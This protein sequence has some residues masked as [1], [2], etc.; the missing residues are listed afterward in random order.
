MS[1]SKYF[2]VLDCYSGFWQ[3]NIH[4]PHREKTAF[5]VPSLGHFQFNRLPFGLSNSPASFQRLM[6]SIF[7]NLTGTECWIFL[8]DLILFSDKA[9]E[10][11]SRLANV[12]ERFR[13]ANLQLQPEKCVFVKDKV[14]YL[15]SEL[16]HKGTEASP[17]KV[18]AVQN[19]PT[20]RSVKN[21]R[22]FLGLA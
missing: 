2:S 6:D 17:D 15:G 5:S 11:A 12:F 1:G 14:T 8:D 9:E 3:I 19:F 21:V 20:P 7:R 4:E 16:S 22:S 18:K 10:H 13:K